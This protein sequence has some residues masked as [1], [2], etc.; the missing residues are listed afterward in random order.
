MHYV[1][2]RDDDANAFTDPGLLKWLY[3]PFVERRQLVHLAVIPEVDPTIVGPDGEREGFIPRTATGTSPAAISQNLTLC[4]LIADCPS[5]AVLQHGLSHAY[6]DGH[7]EFDRDDGRDLH[8]RVERGRRLLEEA[9]LGA[10]EGFVAPQDKMSRTA[11]KVLHAHFD[12]VS[13]GW[14]SVARL[15]KRMRAHYL[16]QNKALGQAH[17]GYLGTAFL[18]HPGCILSYT[19]ESASILPELQRQILSR[20]LTVVV[21]HHWEY[22]RGGKRNRPMVEAL[23][24]LSAWLQ[25]RDDVQVVTARQ[26]RQIVLDGLE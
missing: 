2:L 6:V 12:F 11:A 15:P 17:W 13:T 1:L 8:A 26:A 16:L 5:F 10:I 4:R 21:S 18:S 23:H 14:F 25:E 7:Y 24:G 20:D 22:V 3:A 9:K 19:R